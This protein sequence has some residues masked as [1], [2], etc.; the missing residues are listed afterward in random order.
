MKAASEKIE[1]R[2]FLT[3]V[4]VAPIEA[5]GPAA[6][7]AED[8]LEAGLGE[9]ARAFGF[10]PKPVEVK[11]PSQSGETLL[12]PSSPVADVQR[13]LKKLGAATYGSKAEADRVRDT[14]EQAGER[15]GILGGTTAGA[16]DHRRAGRAQADEGTRCAEG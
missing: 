11:A 9:L 8:K 16:E 3:L 4:V 10:A 2:R 6:I 13:R 12:K 14:A 1:L 5:A 15:V 7:P